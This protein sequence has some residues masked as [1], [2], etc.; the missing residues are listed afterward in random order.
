KDA[1]K[2]R[3]QLL[4]DLTGG[5][6]LNNGDLRKLIYKRAADGEVVPFPELVYNSPRGQTK[7]GKAGMKKKNKNVR[8]NSVTLTAT[9][10][11]ALGE[12]SPIGIEQDPRE[13]L[14]EWLRAPENPY[15]TRAIVNRVWANYFGIGLINPTDDMNLANPASN[16]P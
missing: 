8:Q 3:K 9:Q 7:R 6:K 12:S 4:D 10:G 15:F 11:Y 5:K 13:E 2:T 1:V 16:V 14:M